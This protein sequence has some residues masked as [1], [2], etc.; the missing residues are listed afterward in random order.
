MHD[1]KIEKIAEK[2]GLSVEEVTAFMEERILHEALL[3]LDYTDEEIT[4]L[5]REVHEEIFAQ[6][7]IEGLIPEGF[8]QGFG[9]GMKDPG[10]RSNFGDFRTFGKHGELSPMHEYQSA[11]LAEGLGI[12]V[13]ELNAYHEDGMTF[14]E[15]GDELG[16]TAE[17]VTDIFETARQAAFDQAVEEG[18]I[19]ENAGQF[20]PDGRTRSPGNFG[21][22]KGDRGGCMFTQDN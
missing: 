1:L 17:E 22:A 20:N 21:Q 13:D 18:L 16:F 4:D 12:T 7:Q 8:G 2:T 6:A 11:A 14:I 9:P 10:M 3:D 15:I 19:P 5:M